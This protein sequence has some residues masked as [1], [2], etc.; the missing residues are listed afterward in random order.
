MRKIT[1][2]AEEKATMQLME[3]INKALDECKADGTTSEISKK[4]FWRRPN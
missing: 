4:W 1:V 3:A 2:S